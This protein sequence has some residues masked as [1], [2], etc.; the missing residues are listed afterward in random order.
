M[1]RLRPTH[2]TV[3]GTD[4]ELNALIATLS[5]GPVAIGDGP[6][7]SNRSLI[8][9]SCTEDGLLLQVR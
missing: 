2:R 7:R 1:R 6:Y 5:T 9:R 4:L 3:P 8:M